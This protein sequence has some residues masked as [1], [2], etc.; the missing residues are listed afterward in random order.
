[1]VDEPKETKRERREAAREARIAEQQRRRRAKRRK[2]ILLGGLGGIVVIALIAFGVARA[3]ESRSRS[4]EAYNAAVASANCTG[5][6]EQ[7]DAGNAHIEN[8]G[9]QGRTPYTSTPPTSG[10]HSGAQPPP[11]T[12]YDEPILNPETY[13]HG[14]EH[15]QIYI[16]YKDLP[17]EDVEL[18]ERIQREH[19]TSTAVMRNPTIERPVAITAWTHMQQCDRV[20]EL[21]IERF[22]EERCNKSPERLTPTC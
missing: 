16:H 14:L 6:E 17:P 7:E 15:G 18:L 8:L 19:E 11:P 10:D 5:I 3:L 4:N 22:I 9:D 1:M 21:V 13:V 20:N 2:K 12:F